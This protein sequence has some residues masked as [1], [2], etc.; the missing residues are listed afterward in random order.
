[1]LALGYWPD[2]TIGKT[3]PELETHK[4]GLIVADPTTG[5]TSRPGV[6]AGGDAVKLPGAIIHAI[7]AGR[8]A[9]ASID[10]ALGGSGEIEE[11]LIQREAPNPRIGKDLDFAT[12]PRERMPKL[13]VEA[14]RR[15]FAEVSL[16][17]NR[18]Q[19]A[20]EARRCL[21]CDLRLKLGCNPSPP[22]SWLAFNLETINQIPQS[23]GV[24]QLLDEEQNILAIKGT[25]NLRQDLLEQLEDNE[26]ASLFIFEEVKLFSQRESELIQRY[27]QK[28]GEMP[29]GDEDL[30]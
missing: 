19:A 15:G 29:G 5:A 13:E 27:L 11:V 12:R 21:Q 22:Q 3:T 4:W 14:R 6:Y 1:M 24:Y 9:A 18:E 30:F 25:D 28:H 20:N 2:E 23:E 7:A 10:Q 8:K 17:F 16:G 26:K